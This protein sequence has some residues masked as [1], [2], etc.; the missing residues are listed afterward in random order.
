VSYDPL[1]LNA[2]VALLIVLKALPATDPELLIVAAKVNV[3]DAE[4]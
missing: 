1:T 2:Q 4:A 3:A